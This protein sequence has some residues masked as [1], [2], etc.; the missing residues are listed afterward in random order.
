MEL[1]VSR[2]WAVGALLALTM[3]TGVID[4]VCYLRLGK[5]FVANM[6]GNIVFLGVSLSPGTGFSIAGS[7]VALA[8]FVIGAAVGGRLGRR[9]RGSPRRWLGLAFGVESA[10]LLVIAALVLVGVLDGAGPVLVKVFVGVLGVCFGFQNATILVLSP[11]D[12]TTTVLTRTLTG[13]VADGVLG[14]G[15]DAKIHRRLGSVVAIF[16]G[17]GVGALLLRVSFSGTLLFAVVL[18]ASAGLVFVLAPD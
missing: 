1:P 11:P 8:G 18:V 10:V 15:K 5:V 9:F 7:L 12:L 2:R 13:L 4:A 17:A 3:A 16:A 6:T 14:G